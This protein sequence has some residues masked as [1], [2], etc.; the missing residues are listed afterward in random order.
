MGW[1]RSC[2]QEARELVG[3][4]FRRIQKRI[5]TPNETSA[6]E[7]CQASGI[8]HRRRGEVACL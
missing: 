8:L 6:Q 2:G 1:E 7:S 3:E 4:G 5:P